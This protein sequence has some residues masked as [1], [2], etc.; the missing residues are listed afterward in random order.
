MQ[1][2]SHISQGTYWNTTVTQFV[3]ISAKTRSGIA[4]WC[5]LA[6]RHKGKRVAL[7]EEQELGCY[8]M[9]GISMAYFSDICEG[10]QDLY[11]IPCDMHLSS[12]FG[13]YFFQSSEKALSKLQNSVSGAEPI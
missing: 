7:E 5:K 10:S 4:K 12:A 11:T 2:I 9:Q 1:G 8:I 6:Q 3:G 13:Y